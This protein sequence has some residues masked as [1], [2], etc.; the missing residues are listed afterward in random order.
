MNKFHVDFVTPANSTF[1]LAASPAAAGFTQLCPGTRACV[2]TPASA[3]NVDG[4]GDRLMFRL[5][6]RNFGDHDAV[7]GNMSVN[8]AGVAGIRWFEMRNMTAG[9]PTIFQ[10]STYAPDTLWRWMGSIAM[11]GQGNI[12]VG[13]SAANST[14][15]PSVRYAGRLVTDPLNT[16]AQGEA[17]L[18]PAG[19][20][21]RLRQPLG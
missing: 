1:T 19:S 8:A 5:P 18:L 10:E 21:K 15:N 17:T 12:A 2:P 14:T 3:T 13:F 6:Y 11:D 4:I 20:S 16:L 9:A 7:V